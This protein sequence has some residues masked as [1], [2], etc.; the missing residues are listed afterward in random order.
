MLYKCFL[1]EWD[2]DKDLALVRR[3]R[4]GTVNKGLTQVYHPFM[5]PWLGEVIVQPQWAHWRCHS[6]GFE[7]SMGRFSFLPRKTVNLGHRW[8]LTCPV[9]LTYAA[10]PS[11]LRVPPSLSEPNIT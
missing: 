10:A 5:A 2:I 11:S 4:R 9:P 3:K 8:P 7:P 1:N 6:Y